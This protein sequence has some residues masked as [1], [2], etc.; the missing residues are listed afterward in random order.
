M[1]FL[2]FSG[3][4][5]ML[6]N[7]AHQSLAEACK[8]P[9]LEVFMA[10]HVCTGCLHCAAKAILH[11]KHIQQPVSVTHSGEQGCEV[12]VKLHDVEPAFGDRA[13]RA[14]RLKGVT[15]TVF[16]TFHSRNPKISGL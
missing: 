10:A 8:A 4:V 14:A 5:E 1:Q 15:V 13:G 16:F 12:Q 7:G 9:F 11:L 3:T 6:N 2:R